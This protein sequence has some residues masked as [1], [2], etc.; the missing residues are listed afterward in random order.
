MSANR[1]STVAAIDVKGVVRAWTKA[2]AEHSPDGLRPSELRLDREPLTRS[3]VAVPVFAWVR[4]GGIPVRVSGHTTAWT[5]RA[6]AVRWFTPSGD[7]HRAW[8]WSSAV[9]RRSEIDAERS[10]WMSPTE[11]GKLTLD[12]SAR[13]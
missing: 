7:E 5:E 9:E 1:P 2:M 10:A 3:P 13:L 6:T 12:Q 4:Y 8:V 11:R